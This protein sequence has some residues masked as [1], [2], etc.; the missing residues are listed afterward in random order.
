MCFSLLLGINN[1]Y[2]L[3]S[4]ED[5]G[6]VKEL[7]K[8]ITYDVEYRGDLENGTNLQEYTIQFNFYDLENEVFADF[9]NQHI[10][11]YQSNEPYLFFSGLHRIFIRYSSCSNAIVR[12][13]NIDLKKVNEYSVRKECSELKDVL[14]VCDPWNQDSI[15]ES[16]FLKKINEYNEEKTVHGNIISFFYKYYLYFIIGILVFVSF[17]IMLIIRNIK[18]NRLD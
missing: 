2:A 8:N 6:R 5:I 9:Y 11:I 4:N 14:D 17:I 12:T 13:M 7:A 15:T 3:C 16:D 18:K 10:S 1:V